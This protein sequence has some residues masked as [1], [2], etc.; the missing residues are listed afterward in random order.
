MSNYKERMRELVEYAEDIIGEDGYA[1]IDVRLPSADELYNPL[2]IGTNLD[3]NPEIY[4]FID[5]QANII[6]ARIP[7][8]I[9]FH[10]SADEQ[11]RQ[12][13]KRLMRRHYTMRSYDV[14]WDAAANTR[15]IIF[16]S[17]FGIAVLA[18]YFTVSVLTGNELFAEILSIVG[19]F[20]LWEAANAILLDRP[21]LRRK[22]NDIEQNISQSIEFVDDESCSAEDRAPLVNDAD[23]SA[24][25]ETIADKEE[26]LH[27]VENAKDDDHEQVQA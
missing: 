4:D 8:R 15:K 13:I 7:L 20:S 9:R 22:R 24:D 18:V 17:L 19:T 6:P 3:L 11:T 26:V 1:V 25:E 5:A 10:G 16:L 2:S 23:V 12:E 14:T 21:A 27:S